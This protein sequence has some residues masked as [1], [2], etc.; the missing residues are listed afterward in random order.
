MRYMARLLILAAF[1]V[2]V[3]AQERATLTVPVV[4]TNSEYRVSRLLLDW[5]NAAITIYLKG[6]NGEDKA[7]S[8]SGPVATTMMVGLNKA[9]LST[10][11]LNQRIFD[12]LIADAC[13][14]ATVTG[15]VP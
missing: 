6:S 9:N 1:A 15:S 14:A 2:P 8:Y 5:D 11:S 4:A 12:R 13:I 7:C 10:R 3:F